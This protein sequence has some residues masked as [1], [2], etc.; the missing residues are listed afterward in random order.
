MA[1]TFSPTTTT[2]STVSSRH[3]AMRLATRECLWTHSTSCSC[4]ILGFSSLTI[5]TVFGPLVF[6]LSTTTLSHSYKS[7]LFLAFN[8][9]T[10]MLRMNDNGEIPW[11]G[12]GG[13]AWLASNSTTSHYIHFDICYSKHLPF[14]WNCH[15]FAPSAGSNSHDS[16]SH[17]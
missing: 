2:M 3:V 16:R 17:F 9:T 14:S 12:S 7:W 13:D 10:Y 8:R 6:F 5:M 1:F 15:L 11:S 4:P